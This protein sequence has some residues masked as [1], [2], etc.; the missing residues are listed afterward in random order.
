MRRAA[1]LILLMC[2]VGVRMAAAQDSPAEVAQQADALYAQADF[3]AARSLYEVL[4]AQGVHDSAIYYNLGHTYLELDDLG[5]AML[6]Y[7]RAQALAPR[8]AEVSAALA[9][10]RVLRVDLQGDEAAA[11]DSLATFT[12]GLFTLPELGWL[13]LGV[14][15]LFFA[16]L[17]ALIARRDWRHYLQGPLL[18]LALLVGVGLVLWGSRVYAESFRPPG[19]VI[20]LTAPVM[21]GPGED[22]LLLYELHA[23]A[24]L[25][26]LETRE[27]WLRFVLPDDRQG[28][29]HQDNV[30]KI[31]DAPV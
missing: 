10:I 9:R 3:E 16:L 19:V 21:S 30:R 1:L 23:A 27:A 4:I 6:S 26:I 13:V 12:A 7:R 22:Y 24:E 20:E 11:I 25:R 17:G 5:R 31:Q 2:A 14:W 29:I 28:W 15:V 8:D 18:A